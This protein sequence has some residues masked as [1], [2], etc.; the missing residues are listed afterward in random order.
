MERPESSGITLVRFEM[1][2]ISLFGFRD[3][4]LKVAGIDLVPSYSDNSLS[5]VGLV[6][7]VIFCA[8]NKFTDL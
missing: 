7:K 1:P 8:G 4:G 2:K 3:L 6:Q 5:P